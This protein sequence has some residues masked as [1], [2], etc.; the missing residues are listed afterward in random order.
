MEWIFECDPADPG[1]TRVPVRRTGPVRPAR[2]GLNRY[3]PSDYRLSAPVTVRILGASL[4]AAGLV[5]GL[6]ALAG[7]V[8]SWPA[9][10]TLGTAV[11]LWVVVA[12]LALLLL[13]LAPV[14]RLDDLGYRVRWVR[15]A[16]VRQGRWKDVEDVAATHVAGARCVVLRRKDGSTTTIPVTLVAG[17]VEDFVE[18]LREHLNR[19]HG[20]RR[21]R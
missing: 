1:V 3:V 8:L 20:Y 14:V 10:V 18:D 5:V 13:R 12:V 16:G 2:V 4:A 7:A 11:L 17:P 6:V 21:V 19:G 9:S 15:G